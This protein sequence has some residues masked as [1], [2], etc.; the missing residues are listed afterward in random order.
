M[1]AGPYSSFLSQS[2][3]D[4][5]AQN[6]LILFVA[7]ALSTLRIRGLPGLAN[8]FLDLAEQFSIVHPNSHIGL[9]L[10]AFIVD[11]FPKADGGI[12]LGKYAMPYRSE[13][14]SDRSYNS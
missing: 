12:H 11:G 9:G 2:R 10:V 7:S 5:H 3:D 4:R 14:N 1:T 13:C 6:R 8:Q